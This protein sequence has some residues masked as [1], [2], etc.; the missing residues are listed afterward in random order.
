MDESRVNDRF[1]RFDLRGDSEERIDPNNWQVV[2]VLAL[3]ADA[4][5]PFTT[6]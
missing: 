4:V 2:T 6:I 3:L 1:D 5:K